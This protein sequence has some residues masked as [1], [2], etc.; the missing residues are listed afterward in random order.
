M[1]QQADTSQLREDDTVKSEYAPAWDPLS[2]ARE[3]H[4]TSRTESVRLAVWNIRNATTGGSNAID[5]HA[6]VEAEG[7]DR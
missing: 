3:Q 1:R 4:V 7:R 2:I 6:L 5:G